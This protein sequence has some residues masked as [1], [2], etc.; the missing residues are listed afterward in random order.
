[1]RQ[2]STPAR[3]A[4]A[5]LTGIACACLLSGAAAA[6]TIPGAPNMVKVAKAQGFCAQRDEGICQEWRFAR[7]PLLRL[8]ADGDEDGMDYAFYQRDAA[9]EYHYIVRIY[10][11]L[12][13]AA[14]P[15]RLF[16]GYTWDIADIVVEPG[17]GQLQVQGSFAHEIEDEGPIENQPWQRRVPVVLFEGTTT[18]PDITVRAHEFHPITLP[19]LVTEATRSPAPSHP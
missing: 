12:R 3:R 16:W 14:R 9:G 10:P 18:Q 7:A 11:A 17:N 13:D 4:A 5:G 6:Q 19:A 1:M 2:L 8:V 15:G